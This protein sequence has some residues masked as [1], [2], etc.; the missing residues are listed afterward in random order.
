MNILFKKLV[1]G[2]QMTKRILNLVYRNRLNI[3]MALVV[4][5]DLSF[6]LKFYE[7]EN[8]STYYTRSDNSGNIEKRFT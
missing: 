3:Y 6:D 7:L 4:A 1:L 8:H 5:D 2:N